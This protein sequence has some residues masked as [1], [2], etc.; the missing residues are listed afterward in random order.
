[1]SLSPSATLLLHL[2]GGGGG[3]SYDAY[4]ENRAVCDER[5]G[6]RA[7]LRV[8]VEIPLSLVPHPS[9]IVAVDSRTALRTNGLNIE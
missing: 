9:Y 1:M 8:V 7:H 4:R 3:R 6:H 5:Q 2:G